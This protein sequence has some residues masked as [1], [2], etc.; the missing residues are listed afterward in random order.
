MNHT[1]TKDTVLHFFLSQRGGFGTRQD[2]KIGDLVDGDI[3]SMTKADI[4]ARLS[5]ALYKWV[6]EW[7]TWTFASVVT[8][9][10]TLLRSNFQLHAVQ[11][12]IA[13]Y[14]CKEKITAIDYGDNSPPGE[15]Q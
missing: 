8:Q 6:T 2:F 9:G 12:T 4:E 13:M 7:T 15:Q 11:G 1:Y 3:E 5:K 10:E 14:N